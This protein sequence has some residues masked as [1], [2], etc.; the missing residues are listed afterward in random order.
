MSDARTT[1]RPGAAAVPGR[2]AAVPG[3]ARSHDP[4]AGPGPR[5]PEQRGG[6]ARRP[7]ARPAQRAGAGTGAG[8]RTP[9]RLTA[10][11]GAVVTL[12]ATFLGGALDFWL[13]GGSGIVM[14]LAYVAACFQVA[15]RLRPADLAV[16]PIS[17]PIAFAV[18]LLVLGGG[19]GG[20]LVG[21][22]VSLA[23]GL[24]LQA[25]WLFTGTALSAVI[26]LARHIALTRARRRG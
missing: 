3:P 23:T 24:A 17:G 16:A 20:G 5:T 18:T 15:V 14:G 19:P 21:R 13:F 25:G 10:V 26:A 22:I 6:G 8:P 9:H 7:A 12:G 1:D 2:A 11:G 4:D